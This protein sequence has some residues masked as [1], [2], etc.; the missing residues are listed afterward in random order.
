M[1]NKPYTIDLP[2]FCYY[3]NRNYRGFEAFWI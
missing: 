1:K 3:S 2:Y